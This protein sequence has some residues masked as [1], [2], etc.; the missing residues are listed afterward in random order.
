[1]QGAD[2]QNRLVKA[3]GISVGDLREDRGLRVSGPGKHD[4]GFGK[5]AMFQMIQQYHRATGPSRKVQE[6]RRELK[7][8]AFQSGSDQERAEQDAAKR[9]SNKIR[10]GM[11]SIRNSTPA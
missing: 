4:V 6:D 1:M 10:I 7:R 2:R 5:P 8:L 11:F 9:H 3:H